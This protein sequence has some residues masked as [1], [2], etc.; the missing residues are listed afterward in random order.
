MVENERQQT[1]SHEDK[2]VFLY[3]FS[4]K[5]N[6]SM[7]LKPYNGMT[8]FFLK[9]RNPF[10]CLSSRLQATQGNSG[11]T[12]PGFLWPEQKRHTT[13]QPLIAPDASHGALMFV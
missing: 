4:H 6:T 10:S 8:M 2:I 5:E 13:H 11:Y 9:L 12:K 7:R 1:E 3:V